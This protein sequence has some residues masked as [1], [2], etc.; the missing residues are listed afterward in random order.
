MRALEKIAGE[1]NAIILRDVY[2]LRRLPANGTLLDIGVNLGLSAVAAYVRGQGCVR[3]LGLEP[4][5][6]AFVLLLWNAAANGVPLLANDD[7]WRRPLFM[8]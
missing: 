5:P 4:M 3:I 6:E 2:G 1:I 7:E 8:L